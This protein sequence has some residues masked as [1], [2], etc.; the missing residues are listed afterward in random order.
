MKRGTIVLT[1]FP[2]TDLQGKKVRPALVVSS[3]RITGDDVILVFI[4]SVVDEK[5]LG[6]ADFVI[7]KT[8]KDFKETGLK[9]DSVFKMSKIATVDKSI[10]LG[11]L[12]YLSDD[13][14]ELVDKKLRL[15]LEL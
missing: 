4:S 1:P 11:E 9:K 13:L 7:R 5:S 3:S 8:A 14:L 12:G 6:P 10:I 2:F 15:S